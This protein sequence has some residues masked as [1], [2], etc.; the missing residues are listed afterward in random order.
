MADSH[1]FRFGALA[2][3][4]NSGQ[5]LRETAR[6]LQNARFATMLMTDHVGKDRLTAIPALVAAAD[7]ATSLRV[8]TIVLNNDLRNPAVL[9]AE[10]ATADIV[11]GGRFEPGIGAGWEKD[12]YDRSGIRLDPAT[13]RIKRLEE[14]LQ[15]LNAYFAGDRVN[16]S[17]KYYDVSDCHRCHTRFSSRDRQFW[18]AAAAS[19]CC[20]WRPSGPTSSACTFRQRRMERPGLVVGL[21]EGCREADL[22]DPRRRWRAHVEDRTVSEHVRDI[23]DRGSPSGGAGGH[24]T[25]RHV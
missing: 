22:V 3:H 25:I 14:S 11:T 7:A 6:R 13:A 24:E 18:S 20:R 21:G 17:G 19:G 1:P 8:G 4:V 23:G 9:A 10:V 12:D 5:L 2:S 15:I 16:F